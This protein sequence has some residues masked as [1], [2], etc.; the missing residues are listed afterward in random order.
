MNQSITFTQMQEQL[1]ELQKKHERA[2]VRATQLG[3]DV[4]ALGRAIALLG[5]RTLISGTGKIRRGAL[6]QAVRDAV[7]LVSSTVFTSL[8]I[9]A[10][11]EMHQPELEFDRSSVSGSL[12]E[13]VNEN[14][15]VITTES[16]GRRPAYFCRTE[17]QHN[18]NYKDQND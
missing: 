11:I 10:W 4:E 15:L 1:E 18:T 14:L 7:Q 5:G 13:L 12:K 8:D 2:V 6:T 9:T 17:T 3:Q 16:S